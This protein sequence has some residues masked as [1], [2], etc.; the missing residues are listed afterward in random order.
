MENS[1]PGTHTIPG[2]AL[3]GAGPELGIVASNMPTGTEPSGEA[4]L[5]GA[6][7]FDAM[8]Q[9]HIDARKTAA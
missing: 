3:F 1:P 5:T 2:G 6:G 8:S 7:F 4:A 9:P